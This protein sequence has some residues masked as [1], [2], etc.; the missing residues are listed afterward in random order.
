MTLDWAGF[1]GMNVHPR[2]SECNVSAGAAERASNS[3]L[4]LLSEV[5][6][7]RWST[8]SEADVPELP[9]HN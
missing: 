2:E 8:C 3:L 6:S 9:R 5:A 1:T 4:G 7:H